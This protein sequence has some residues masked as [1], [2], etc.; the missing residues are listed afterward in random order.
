MSNEI[1]VGCSVVTQSEHT[2]IG[3]IEKYFVVCECDVRQFSL[4]KEVLG[5]GEL[6]L[7]PAPILS[8]APNPSPRSPSYTGNIHPSGKDLGALTTHTYIVYSMQ[9]S[10]STQTLS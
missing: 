1:S 5:K 8:A 10:K 6:S 4:Y 2:L 3:K 7:S 9:A